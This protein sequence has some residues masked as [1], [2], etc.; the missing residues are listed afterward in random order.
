MVGAGNSAV[1]IAVKLAE[2]SE[3][4][5]ATRS[6]L[7]FLPQIIFGRDIHFWLTVL[8]LDQSKLGRSLLG[9][10]SGVLDTGKY[11]RAIAND[12]PKHRKMF[13]RF[14]ETGVVW[15]DGTTEEVDTVLFATGFSPNYD[16][17]KALDALDSKGYPIE[18]NGIST[19][20]TGL[21][22]VGLHLQTSFASATIRG[23]G[24]DAKYVVRQAVKVIQWLTHL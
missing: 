23:V 15:S 5:I 2:G 14:T 24:K 3:V 10:S 16:Y 1:Q 4:T 13:E 20:S 11:Q 19:K 9:E 12:R 7:K 22:F 21:Y 17:L 18:K 8:G 6:P